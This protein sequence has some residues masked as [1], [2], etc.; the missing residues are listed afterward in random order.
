MILAKLKKIVMI[1]A[2][3]SSLTVRPVSDQVV[4]I[5]VYLLHQLHPLLLHL[6]LLLHLTAMNLKLTVTLVSVLIAITVVPNVQ[7]SIAKHA[8]EK[9]VAIAALLLR[10]VMIL[11]VK[12]V[13]ELNVQS[14]AHLFLQLHLLQ[15]LLHHP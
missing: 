15:L 11:T 9:N 5:V 1:A 7:M 12:S 14:V 10:L 8:A 6:L 4:P 13:L 2:I 3:A